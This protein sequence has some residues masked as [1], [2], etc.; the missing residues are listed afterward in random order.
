MASELD[1]LVLARFRDAPRP[2]CLMAGAGRLLRHHPLSA[3]V[4]ESVKRSSCRIAGA[5]L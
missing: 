4:M 5:E 1:G 2:E 3:N